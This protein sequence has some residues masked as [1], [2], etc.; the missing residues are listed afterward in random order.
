ME[1]GSSQSEELIVPSCHFFY[2]NN[3]YEKESKGIGVMGCSLCVIHENRPKLDG[4]HY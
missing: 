1:P 4:K 3:Q 2:Y